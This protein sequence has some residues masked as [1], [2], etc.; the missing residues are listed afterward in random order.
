MFWVADFTQ[1]AT[2]RPGK[3]A[4]T[5]VTWDAEPAPRTYDVIRGDVDDLEAAG[6][7]VDL[8]TVVCLED[9]SP[10]ND[11]A[12]FEDSLQPSAGQVFFFLYRG[13]Q[14]T[15]DGPGS[16]GRSSDGSERVAGASDCRP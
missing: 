9:D 6:G 11:T 2:I 1:P 13:S 4:P 10:D 14:G 8:G 16:W 12:R 15:F 5:L 3:S 7:Q